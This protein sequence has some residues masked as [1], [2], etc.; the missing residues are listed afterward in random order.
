M[1]I[2]CG[3][4][5]FIDFYQKIYWTYIRNQCKSLLRIFTKGGGKKALPIYSPAI[6]FH[7]KVSEHKKKGDMSFY[8]LTADVAIT[9]QIFIIYGSSCREFKNFRFPPLRLIRKTIL[10]LFTLETLRF[11]C[12]FKYSRT[13]GV[14]QRHI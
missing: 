13:V 5:Y 14:N 1:V 3:Y 6:P 7:T 10:L 12:D 4:Y 8:F 9:E 11:Y 2:I